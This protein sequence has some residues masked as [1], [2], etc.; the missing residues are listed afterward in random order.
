MISSEKYV[1]GAVILVPKDE[2]YTALEQCN[3][4]WFATLKPLFLAILDLRREFMPVDLITLSGKLKGI[5]TPYEIASIT[6]SVS[7]DVNINFHIRLLQ[8]EY[9]KKELN[10]VCATIHLNPNDEPFEDIKA[11]KKAISELELTQ[12]HKLSNLKILAENRIEDLETRRNQTIKTV[13]KASGFAKLD[14]YIGGLVPGELIICAGRPGMGK[15]AFAVNL[16]LAHCKQGGR[17]LMF[18]IEMPENQITDRVLAGETG[19]D[20]YHIRNAELSDWDM[21]NLKNIDLPEGFYINDDSRLTIDKIGAVVKSLRIKYN[22]SFVIMDYL[23][24]ITA[25]LR[26]NREQE[27]AYISGECK[28]IAKE[29]GVCVMA[30]A[31]LSRKVEERGSK[32]PMLADLRESGSIEQD[33]DIVLFPFRPQYYDKEQAEIEPAELH[34]AKCRNGQ[35]GFL[36]ME[37]KG[38][39]TQYLWT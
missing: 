15:T 3:S 10:K 32:I 8:Q 34:I 33:A 20:N 29:S 13:G 35:T 12:E 9:V 14:R 24:L 31:Q 7:S 36:N 5:M 37:F 11:L 25:E 28:R 17:V 18:S 22:I 21:K 4:N 26:R 23:Q 16:G 19:L 27:V 39:T 2:N 30:L 38:K 1:L 6:E